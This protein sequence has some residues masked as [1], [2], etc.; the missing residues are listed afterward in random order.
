MS[1]NS[2]LFTTDLPKILPMDKLY[3]PDVD[4]SSSI[5]TTKF[6]PSV[7]SLLVDDVYI[8][9]V[10]SVNEATGKSTYRPLSVID[11]GATKRIL[12]YGNTFYALFF[13]PVQITDNNG[14]KLQL[15]RLNVDDK[16]TFFGD[17]VTNYCIIK[18]SATG[19]ETIISQ[20]F[21]ETNTNTGRMCKVA[22][23]TDSKKCV[24]CYS[25]DELEAGETYI[26]RAYDS[27]GNLVAEFK[28]IG[29]EATALSIDI[30]E[31]P[32][33]DF[34]VRANQFVS[35]D[36]LGNNA[37]FLYQHQNVD[38]LNI[39]PII[40]YADN[41]E[42]HVVIDN[43][44]G[45]AYGLEEIKTDVVGATYNV[46]IKYA[47]GSN[48]SSPIASGYGDN[49]FV[50]C[51]FDVHILDGN[52]KEIAKIQII[53]QFDINA[54]KWSLGSATYFR[55]RKLTPIITES[56]IIDNFD[57]S[58]TGFNKTQDISVKSEQINVDGSVTT[59]TERYKLEVKSNPDQ[60]SNPFLI[61]DYN[62]VDDR[63][64]GLDKAPNNIPPQM[65]FG[66]QPDSGLSGYFFPK[67]TY[68]STNFN[69][70]AECF[71]YNFYHCANP[72]MSP[73]EDIAPTPTHFNVRTL[74]NKILMTVPVAVEDFENIL[75]LITTLAGVEDQWVGST[76]IIEFWKDLGNNK[77]DILYGVPVRVR[78]YTA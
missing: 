62:T 9:I 51:S 39:W 1:G 27:A 4:V 18:S 49:R 17:S 53:P 15:T 65:F 52:I 10:T 78:R 46:L 25:F 68:V 56:A 42:E 22:G 47:I 54:N 70:K 32:I 61:A 57:G 3:D 24:P 67:N 11:S 59:R 48:V 29:V 6:I 7:N 60:V 34:F 28:L 36:N 33:I 41:T 63:I 20:Y 19:T 71:L 58:D 50:S 64:F 45:F 43:V 5:N 77:F 8:Y 21:D 31:N 75:P 37:I 55:D 38:E 13:A 30:D 44:H 73:E 16:L 74:S 14:N 69:N 2:T 76:L 40:K 66:V 23:A 72:P 26:L 12:E 35:L